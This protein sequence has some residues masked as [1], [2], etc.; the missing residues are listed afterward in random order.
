MRPLIVN[1]HAHSPPYAF[2]SYH[3]HPNVVWEKPNGTWLGLWAREWPDLLGEAILSVDS[4]FRWEVWQPDYR[5]EQVYSATLES[6]VTHRLFPATDR[7]YYPGLRAEV[8]IYSE[9][10]LS[11]LAEIG[12][13]PT[14]L[15][16]HGFR[17]PFYSE[18]LAKCGRQKRYPIFIVGHGMGTAPTSEMAGLH[19]PLTYAR[20]LA[21]H[22][23]LSRLLS[24]VDVI[25]AQSEY[26]RGELRK[27]FR[28]WTELLTMGCDFDFWAPV[29]TAA[30]KRVV[31]SALGIPQARTVFLATG[32]FVPLK[33]FDKLLDVFGRLG[34]RQDYTLLIAGHGD[35]ANTERLEALSRSLVEG[36]KAVLHPYVTGEQLRNLYWAADVYVSASTREGASVSVMKAMACGLP[37]LSTPVGET[38]ERMRR[39]GAGKLIPIYKYNEWKVAIEEILEKGLPPALNRTIARDAYDWPHV[40]RRFVTLY[41]SLSERYF[42]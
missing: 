28:G 9:P 30:Q 19:R 1:I 15:H 13:E 23:K 5:A 25:S 7:T 22:W 35:R 36:G 38:S 6:G 34:E 11:S 31:R 17:V 37:V 27:I 4:G 8:G 12:S 20:L 39:Y 42:G 10:I 33:Q 41:D 14:I 2:A 3:D 26:A 32:N 18:I 24:H 21:E 29:P 16:L 40:A